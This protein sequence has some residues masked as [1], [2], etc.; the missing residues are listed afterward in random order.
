MAPPS[1]RTPA[2][3]ETIISRV[4]EGVPLVHAAREA[5]VGVATWNEWLEGDTELASR[6]ARARKDG[7]DKIA[8][9]ALSIADE[10]PPTNERGGTDPGYVAWQKNRVWTRLQLLSKWD[11]RYADKLAIGGAEDLPPVKTETTLAPGEA[12]K[13]LLGGES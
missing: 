2:V 7:H 12:Y 6:F 4:S 10:M 5:G 1:K 13:R 3:V 8:A 11:R 9:D